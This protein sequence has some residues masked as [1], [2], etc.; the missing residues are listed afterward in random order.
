MNGRK[1]R[2]ISRA[3]R[4]LGAKPTAYITGRNNER[5]CKVGTYREVRK[6]L[7]REGELKT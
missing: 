3:A 7:K 4:A 5:R 6:M 2:A 1:S